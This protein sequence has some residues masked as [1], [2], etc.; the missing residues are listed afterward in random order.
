MAKTL[1]Q[2][3]D[4][5]YN[6]PLE[7]YIENAPLMRERVNEVYPQIKDTCWAYKEGNAHLFTGDVKCGLQPD[8][9]I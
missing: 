2:F 1:I 3:I 7:E 6:F 5:S 9:V 8:L 4:K